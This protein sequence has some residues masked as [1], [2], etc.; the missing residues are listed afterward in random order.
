MARTKANIKKRRY[1]ALHRAPVAFALPADAA[2]FA[3]FLATF[4]ELGICREK[5]LNSN[6]TKGDEETLDDGTKKALG[7]NGRLEGVLLQSDPTDYTAYETIEN[8]EQ[9]ILFLSQDGQVALFFP[10]A[11]LFFEE[12]V[13][14][15]DTEAI[16]FSYE[17][18]NLTQKS[19]FRTRFAVPQS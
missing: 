2:E 1:R 3:T 4:T 17:V 5:T 13:S 12:T 6:I 11:T 8:V 19:D 18:E 14:G 15:G 10:N 16:P 7:Y 9:D